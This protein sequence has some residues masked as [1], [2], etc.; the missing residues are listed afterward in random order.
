MFFLR[1]LPTFED[2]K[3]I[4]LYCFC[5][6]RENME[7]YVKVEKP[8]VETPIDENEIRIT[9]QGRMRNYISYAMTLLQVYIFSGTL[10]AQGYPF[11]YSVCILHFSTFVK[12]KMVSNWM[13]R[14]NI[15]FIK[16]VC[17]IILNLFIKCFFFI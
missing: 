17:D 10:C 4:Q 15:L 6:F 11:V 9:S 12:K 5:I 1:F 2:I 3:L 16:L 14:R 7:Q 13:G 8:K